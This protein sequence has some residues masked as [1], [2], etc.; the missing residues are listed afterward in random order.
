[1]PSTGIINGTNLRVYEGSD[2]VAYATEG[3]FSLSRE[4]TE[5][6]HKDNA[7]SGWAERSPHTKS[8]TITVSALYADDASS[9]NFNELFTAWDGGTSLT[10]KF[11]TE[12]TGDDFWSGS[13][14]CESIELNAPDKD[15]ASYS[16]TFIST[17]AITMSQVA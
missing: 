1:M 16:A 2:A 3:N 9:T 7:G 5:Q 12:V 11:S 8:A 13:F 10:L 4:F 6:L 17:G 15:D 14:Y